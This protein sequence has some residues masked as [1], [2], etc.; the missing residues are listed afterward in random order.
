MATQDF[1]HI[2]AAQTEEAAPAS[3]TKSIV[4]T[5]VSLVVVLGTFMGGFWLGQK[6]GIEVASGEDKAR[7]EKMLRKQED[8]LKKL[9]DIAA[10][11][12]ETKVST[13]QVGE[14]TFYNELPKQPAQP[15]GLRG[16][17][18]VMLINKP[19]I[20]KTEREASD[21]KR[22]E[23]IRK[24]IEKEL[25]QGADETVKKKV[26]VSAVK[27]AK[28][29][30]S[31]VVRAGG[32]ILQVASFQQE[33]DA[34]KF[35]SKLRKHGFS[36]VVK[37]VTLPNLGIWYRV[38]LEGFASRKAADDVRNQLKK[39]MNIKALVVPSG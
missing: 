38:Y 24:M 2:E 8:E 32:Y 4:I 14:L 7:L 31:K 28:P 11:K 35:L 34:N 18:D 17:R 5:I 22:R 27:P 30:V 12:A 13:T 37:Q 26:A 1:A 9:R 15:E 36:P 10:L 6:H 3:Y 21:A 19:V 33:A 23:A 39:T 16:K 25:Q 20:A 29:I